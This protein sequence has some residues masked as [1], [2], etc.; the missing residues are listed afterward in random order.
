MKFNCVIIDDDQY[1]ID[2]LADYIFKLEHLELVASYID[3]IVALNTIKAEDEF[4]FIFLDIEM[5]RLNGLELAQ[6][7][8]DKAKYLIFTTSH[9]T[10]A[11][12]AFDLKA[13]HYLLKPISFAKFALVI[14]SLLGSEIKKNTAYSKNKRLRFIKGDS[15]SAYQYIDTDLITYIEAAG[16]YVVIYTENHQQHITYMSLNHMVTALE[17]S[18][19]IR[20]N[21]SHVIAKNSIRKVEGNVIYLKNDKTFQLGDTYR[22]AF[23]TFLNDHLLK[24]QKKADAEQT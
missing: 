8:R 18:D 1:A 10:H 11:I 24:G 9:T 14:S 4:D 5:P 22:S 7:L 17:P 19:F 3:P 23:I 13:S 21:K 15:K 6:M 12:D 2:A 20:V 16:N